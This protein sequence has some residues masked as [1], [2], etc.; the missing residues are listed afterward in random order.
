[1]TA[2]DESADN[3]AQASFR[4]A[5]VK[6]IKNPHPFGERFPNLEAAQQAAPAVN[7]AR[8]AGGLKPCNYVVQLKLRRQHHWPFGRYVAAE[9]FPLAKHTKE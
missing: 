3:V 1:M 6:D 2:R 7:Q 9:L 5:W 4:L 8:V